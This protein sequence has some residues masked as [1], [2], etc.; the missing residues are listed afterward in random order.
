MSHSPDAA[1]LH[2][3]RFKIIAQDV[4]ADCPTFSIVRKLGGL[5]KYLARTVPRYE[6]V[7]EQIL[8]QGLHFHHHGGPVQP[9]CPLT[10]ASFGVRRKRKS[11]YDPLPEEQKWSAKEGN[12]NII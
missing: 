5:Q 9:C 7:A 2:M 3:E 8:S 1:S 4:A 6:K 11:G 10:S 12:L